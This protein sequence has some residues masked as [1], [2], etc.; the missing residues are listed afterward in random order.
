MNYF[1]GILLT[2]FSLCN[3]SERITGPEVKGGSQGDQGWISLFNG[4]DL[5]GWTVRG[6]AVWTVK[7]GVLIG[8]SEEGHGHIYA[9]PVV[10]DL[11]VKGMFRLSD[12]GG[13]GNSG[14]YFRANPPR[15]NPDGYPRGY[16]AQICHSQEAYTGWLWKPGTPT[17]RASELV[18]K[19]DEWFS[20]RVK[21]EGNLIR[22]WVNSQLV[23][24]HRDD[25]YKKGSFSIQCHNPGMTIEAKE[26]YYRTIEPY[27]PP[28]GYRSEFG[29]KLSYALRILKTIETQP[30]I[31]EGID[32]HRD[33]VYREVDSI[34][35][36]LDIYQPG[37]LKTPAPLLVFI[38]GGGWSKGDKADYLPYLVDYAEKGYVTA[39]ISYRLSG[40]ATYPAALED[41][42]SALHWLRSIAADHMIDP[43][44]MALIGGSAGGHLA[45]LAA[46]A[47]QP[48][49][50]IRAVV[51]IYGPVD[52]T[53]PYARNRHECL[54]FL[55][56]S[57]Q[58]SP[59]LYM[60]ASPATHISSDDPPTLIFH[61]TL[62][63]LVPVSQS[64]S[65]HNWLTEAGVLNE[66]HRLKGWPHT[67]DLSRKVNDYCQHRMDAF[68]RSFL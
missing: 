62:D 52:L 12:Q 41:V 60:A 20:L 15:D 51:N 16:E 39:S 9:G 23:M 19:D 18:S 25:E 6:N 36:K 58:E 53:T 7:E 48:I 40:I 5:E 44:R 68:F 29:L 28:K 67:M 13:G 31:P 32:G 22:I 64:D 17:G 24:I 14:L 49:P 47:G 33:L 54:S 11:E 56:K 43:D 4:T 59:G 45:M 57:Y 63:S 8:R 66:Y 3:T 42:V 10:K 65:L 30:E 50:G 26:L 27:K 21:A 61:G 34:P 2:L 38:H 46:Y 37:E 1:S 35:M 55:G